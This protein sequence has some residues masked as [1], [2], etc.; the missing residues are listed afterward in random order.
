MLKKNLPTL[1]LYDYFSPNEVH[2]HAIKSYL[3]RGQSEFQDIAIA[4]TNSYG[5]CL[6]LDNEVQSFEVDEFIYHEAIV[7]PALILHPSPA[8]VAIIGGGEGS[9][10]REVLRFKTINKAI[11]IDID[12]KVVEC[13]KQYLPS[14]HDGCFSDS[15][16]TIL[17]EDGRKYLEDTDEKFDVIIMD[18]TCPVENG[19]A[20][21]LFTEEFYE[22]VSKSLTPQGI[23]SVQASTTLPMALD[24]YTIIC[25]TIGNVFPNVFPYAAYIPSF[26]M[27][28]GYCLA[29]K[30]L[31]PFKISNED[32]E[33]R[34]SERITGELR[35]YDSITHQ[36]LFNLPKYVRKALA[37]QTRINSDSQPFI[38]TFPGQH[39][40]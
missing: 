24:S 6:I 5:R 15:K 7:D 28:W 33:Q 8:N 27:P 30:G 2:K 32:I 9:T 16:A 25:K 36:L 19:P 4:E 29:T 40:V 3:Y 17:H 1:W 34:I 22:I 31:D 21:K 23:L 37:G 26:A 35:Y 10:L 18:I 12:S 39:V 38:E 13:A 14:F 20:Y 11:M